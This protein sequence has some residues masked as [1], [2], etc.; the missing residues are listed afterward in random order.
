MSGI[1]NVELAG[2]V[3]RATITISG[4]GNVNA[5]DLK[6]QTVDITIPGLGSATVWVTDQLNGDIKGG[7]SVSYYGD[8]KTNTKTSGLGVEFCG[9]H[10][11]NEWQRSP[12][13]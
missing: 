7:G 11:M 9:V 13:N 3:A 1:G 12:N 10:H 2:Q 6:C 5:A 8:P 4:A